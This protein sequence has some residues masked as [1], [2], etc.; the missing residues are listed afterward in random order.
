MWK[1]QKSELKSVH[2]KYMPFGK[3]FCTFPANLDHTNLPKN[4]SQ[5]FNVSFDTKFVMV[6]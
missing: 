6:S 5:N 4:D 3:W 2:V 1:C